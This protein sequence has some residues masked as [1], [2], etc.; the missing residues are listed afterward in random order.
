[1]GIKRLSMRFL[2]AFSLWAGFGLAAEAQVPAVTVEEGPAGHVARVGAGA[3]IQKI[4]DSLRKTPFSLPTLGAITRQTIAGATA[5]ATHGT[6]NTSL[7]S[8]VRTMRLA[9]YHD[10]GDPV[11][12]TIHGGDELLAARASLG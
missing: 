1:M 3:T 12:R 5:T 10:R 6:G 7:S 2:A 11:I 8:F 4:L 9:C